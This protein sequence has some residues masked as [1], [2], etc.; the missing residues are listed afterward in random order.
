G[1]Q[2]EAT[3]ELEGCAHDRDPRAPWGRRVT[4]PGAAA[5]VLRVAWSG[6]A[7]PALVDPAWTATG[8]MAVARIYPSASV[9]GSDRVLLAGGSTGSAFV[10]SAELYDPATATFGATGS[11]TAGRFAHTATVLTSGNVLVAGGF[12]APNAPTASAELYDP[13]AGTFSSTGSM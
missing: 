4:S 11:M 6:V 3:L 13:V 9:L 10:S 1:A 5:C 2:R 7:Y 8:S 12:T